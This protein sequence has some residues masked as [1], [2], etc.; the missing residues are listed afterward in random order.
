M[1]WSVNENLNLR[2]QNYRE[3]H[4]VIFAKHLVDSGVGVSNRI[5][6]LSCLRCFF[7][8]YIK[9]Q[10]LN[11]KNPVP[12]HLVK[13]MKRASSRAIS[14][15][16]MK[17][18][19][20]SFDSGEQ[21]SFSMRI[22]V[23][24]LYDGAARISEILNLRLRDIRFGKSK[25]DPTVFHVRRKGNKFRDLYVSH[26]TMRE[27]KKYL[28]MAGITRPDQPVFPNRRDPSRPMT[29]EPL[30]QR[31][32]KF[33]SKM[34]IIRKIYGTHIGRHSATYHMLARGGNPYVIADYLSHDASLATT[35]G[36]YGSPQKQDVIASYRKHMPKIDLR[37]C[38]TLLGRISVA[39]V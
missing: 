9:K 30:Q 23:R 38:R 16:M 32:A 2:P 3:T 18:L 14:E 21:S 33:L 35:L 1:A 34:G 20:N 39:H 25:T 28:K 17:K 29:T 10:R 36:V 13:Q 4:L 15:K 11:M 7:R 27:L 12:F 19:I 6:T 22:V 26:D 24:M 8:D 37:K 31:I 5:G